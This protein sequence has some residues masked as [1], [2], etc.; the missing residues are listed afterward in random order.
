MWAEDHSDEE[1]VTDFD[2]AEHI[3]TSM[4]KLDSPR[5]RQVK[6]KKKK[7]PE[8]KEPEPTCCTKL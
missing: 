1:R 8:E 2:E 7:E 4:P 6:T 5:S 3:I